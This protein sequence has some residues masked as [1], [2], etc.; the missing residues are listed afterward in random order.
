M[1]RIRL[2]TAFISLSFVLI[3]GLTFV[4]IA[5]GYRFDT[6]K[7]KLAPTGLFVVTSSPDGAQ[8]LVN[9]ELESAT[10]ATISLVPDTYDVEVKKEGYL[11][12]HKRITI[13]KEE[14]TKVDTVLFPSTPSLSGLTATGALSPVLSPDGTKVVFGIPLADHS[15]D[16]KVGLWIMDLGNLPIGFSNDPRQISTI[17]PEGATW[18]W[19]PDSRKILISAAAASFVIPTG[20]LT[21]EN[22]TINI[23]GAKLDKTIKEWV[24]EEAG[25]TQPRLDRLPPPL[26]DIL[27]RKTSHLVFSPDQNKVLYTAS[28]SA[29]IAENLIP[30]L[31][32]SS[33]QKQERNIKSGQIYVYDIKEDRNFLILDKSEGVYL[34]D[35]NAPESTPSAQVKKSSAKL[36]WFPT[37]NHLIFAEPEKITI[38]DYDGT[39]RQ[40]VWSGPYEP[41]FAIPY[42]SANRLLI[43]TRLGAGNSNFPN[44]YTLSL[45]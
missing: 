33:T 11:G 23:R 3:V 14:V 43:L 37:S 20:S 26:K 44:L 29:T 45:K 42:P 21:R 39:N 2:L 27:E 24:Q 25:L 15:E 7:L 36:T 22:E 13:K 30:L 12:W 16:Q 1:S 38:M 9:G 41:P 35:W 40:V 28:G 19:S 31:P 17:N 34:G 4:Y 6:K 5:R 8:I 32:G 10:N 18:N